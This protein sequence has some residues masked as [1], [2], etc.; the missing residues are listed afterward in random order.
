MKLI[1]RTMGENGIETSD[2]LDPITGGTHVHRVQDVEPVLDANKAEYNSHGDLKSSRYGKGPMHK[3]ASIPMIVV[4]KW[5][6]EG[7]NIYTATPQEIR[8][9]LNDPEYKYLRTMPGKL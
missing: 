3:I 9:K 7:F 1:E 4:E 2:Y 6:K 8:R 5:M